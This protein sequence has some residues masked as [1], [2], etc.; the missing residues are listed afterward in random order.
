MTKSLCLAIAFDTNAFKYKANIK[1]ISE[2]SSKIF[3]E[4]IMKGCFQYT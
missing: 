3:L 4:N 2:E 1:L